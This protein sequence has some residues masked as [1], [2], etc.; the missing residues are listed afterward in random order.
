MD[1]DANFRRFVLQQV[2][3][4]ALLARVSQEKDLPQ[5]E[6]LTEAAAV[7]A[8]TMLMASGISGGRANAF[9]ST[10]TLVN[11]LSQIA[12]YRDSL[13]YGVSLSPYWSSLRALQIEAS[14]RRQP[15]AGL[16]NN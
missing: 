12:Q 11:L 10:T 7:L 16:D 4:D 13:L 8:G 3:V 14:I 1:N 5:D 9:S 2:T 6:L 15:L